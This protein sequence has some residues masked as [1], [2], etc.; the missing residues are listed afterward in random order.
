MNRQQILETSPMQTQN[1]VM[2]YLLMIFA[3]I[4]VGSVFSAKNE[5]IP[6]REYMEKKG[7]V[8]DLRGPGLYIAYRCNGLYTTMR[9]LMSG[10]PQEGAEDIAKQM[11]ERQNDAIT[12]ARIFYNKL[13]PVDERD[14][15]DNLVRSVMP[16]SQ[17]Y[18]D[19]ANESWTN[20]GSYFDEYILDDAEV[21]NLFIDKIV[22]PE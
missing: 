17:K 9:V 22:Q 1:A 16:M 2:K 11:A 3:L 13:T 7:I 4:F 12:I 6:L 19:V 21:C 14:F 8:E 18:Q 10:A 15:E 20:T 5:M